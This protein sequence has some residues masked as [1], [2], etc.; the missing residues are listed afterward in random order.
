MRESLSKR[1]NEH[2]RA[3]RDDPDSDRRVAHF[4]RIRLV[5][6]ALPE[7]DLEAVDTSDTFLG[8][9]LSFPFLISSMTGGRGDDLARI[10]RNLAEA[11]E[12]TGVAMGVGSQRVMLSEPEAAASFDLRAIAPSVPLLA[13]LG[14][15][16]LN[17]GLGVDDCRRCVEIL[18]ADALIFHCNPLQEIIQPGGDTDFSRLVEKIGAV[19]ENLNVPVIVKGVGAGVDR[20][21]AEALLGV[22]V[23]ILDVAG[24]GGTSWS[25]IEQRRRDPDDVHGLG[26]QF[27]DW[28]L[29]TPVAL[30][31]LEPFGDRL[32][33]IAS[34]GIRGGVDM[35][36]A[37]I[38]GARLCGMARPLLD[39]ALESADSVIRVIERIR[40]EYR[41]AQYLLGC[42]ETASLRGNTSLI[43]SMPT[44][45]IYEP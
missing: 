43:V 18:D 34:G 45:W 42:A 20:A 2:I 6:R 5:H 39:P 22:G 33:R 30:R 19:A 24:A 31:R 14:A 21:D 28:G 32:T 16:Q 44:E 10:N 36:K 26:Y 25:R 29:P 9:S 4:D 13:N 17:R 40:V 27:Q 7:L 37:I 8:K 38:L 11:A 41:T 23:A 12:R 3:L 1:K 15:A 35:A